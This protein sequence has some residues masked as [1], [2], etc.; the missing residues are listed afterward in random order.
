[1]N[2]AITW[3]PRAGAPPLGWVGVVAVSLGNFM[4]A[5][6]ASGVNV[7]LPEIA[8]DLG[9]GTV[10]RQW[11]LDGY[12]VPLCAVLLIAGVLGDR[13][14]STRVFRRATLAFVVFSVLCA[15]APNIGFLI[16]MRTGQGVAAGF[17]LPMTLSVISRRI[18]E[19][20]RRTRAIG[21]WGVVGGIAIAAAP[22][23]AA[24]L[25][26]QFGWWAV[27]VCNVPL[28][29]IAL[30]LLPSVRDSELGRRHIDWCGQVLFGLGLAAVATGLIEFC[31]GALEAAAVC[32]LALVGIGIALVRHLRAA[33]EPLVPPAVFNRAFTPAVIS[34]TCYQFAAYGSLVVLPV[35]F[36][37]V[38]HADVADVGLLMVP[39]CAGWL[40][41]NVAAL[42]T[43]HSRH[44]VMLLTA[45][46][47]GAVAALGIAFL[48]HSLLSAAL[49][50]T[51]VLGVVA[52]VLASTLSGA[53]MVLATP[54]TSG[55]SAGTF[56]V[57]RQCGMVIAIAVLGSA[58]VVESP[59]L[60]FSIIAA[61][62]AAMGTSVR[63]A[64]RSHGVRTT[65]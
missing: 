40:A 9:A 65:P 23:F 10:A 64:L 61:V 20:E 42:L 50:A 51:A 2:T 6:D 18:P 1:M 49:I 22:I 28:C 31:R 29:A 52:G 5:F 33:S 56:N 26:S 37:V 54:G 59:T 63:L 60:A 24:V 4:V 62:F 11:V 53:A 25:V 45:P 14:G 41:G 58:A 30:A 21:V 13:V 3:S 55:I 46:A 39:C 47:I 15:V 27:F 48:V 35:Y 32:A 38:R 16:A 34:G 7:A 8:A 44:R 36:Q 12:S 43:P 19:P 17:M 57:G